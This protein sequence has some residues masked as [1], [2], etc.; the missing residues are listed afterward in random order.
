MLHS[1]SMTVCA[2]DERTSLSMSI[3]ECYG[4]L[5]SSS[6]DWHLVCRSS[7]VWHLV[8]AHP[9]IPKGGRPMRVL[10]VEDHKPLVRALRRGLEEEGYAVDVAE[11][12]EEADYKACSTNYD[13]IVLDLMLPKKDGL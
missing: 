6:N 12:G 4:L 7:K 10:I 1:L 11:D 8:H 2:G 3:I 13:A 9:P 5:G